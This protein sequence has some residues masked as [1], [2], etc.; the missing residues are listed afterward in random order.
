MK[1]YNWIGIVGEI[2]KLIA[3]GMRTV[4]KVKR[5]LMKKGL[6]IRRILL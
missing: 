2:L 1:A 6:I 5:K 4:Y 3:D